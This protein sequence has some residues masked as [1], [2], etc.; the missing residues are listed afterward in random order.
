MG[1]G[2]YEKS[3]R[4]VFTPSSCFVRLFIGDEMKGDGSALVG[5]RDGRVGLVVY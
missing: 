5:Y 1:L 3:K 4:K 2:S